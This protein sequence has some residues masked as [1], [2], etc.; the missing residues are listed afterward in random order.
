[1]SSFPLFK[2]VTLDKCGFKV[3]SGSTFG[4]SEGIVLAKMESQ[5]INNGFDSRG[6]KEVMVANQRRVGTCEI[7]VRI[8]ALALTLAAAVVLGVD[9]QSKVVPVK[10]VDSLP[11]LNVEVTAKWHYLSAFV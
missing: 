8:L 7:L 11:P 2:T 3:F 4:F 6:E 5:K 10:V 1:M 9:K